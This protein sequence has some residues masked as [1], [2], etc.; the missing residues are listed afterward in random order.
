[1]FGSHGDGMEAGGHD[2]LE[3]ALKTLIVIQ[4]SV[5]FCVTSIIGDSLKQNA[6][7]ISSMKNQLLLRRGRRQ[8]S[9]LELTPF[10]SSVDAVSRV[11]VSATTSGDVIVLYLLPSCVLQLFKQSTS[12][13]RTRLQV[14]LV[15]SYSSHTE[16]DSWIPGDDRK[17]ANSTIYF[18]VSTD[19]ADILSSF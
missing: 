6:I 9:N 11:A 19:V 1:M 4:F 17:C 10:I 14:Q 12:G 18:T 16:L 13:L 15:C 5:Y 8:H 2:P 3:L 7:N